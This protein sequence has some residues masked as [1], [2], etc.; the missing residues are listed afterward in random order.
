ML[1]LARET[2][3][4]VDLGIEPED[5]DKVKVAMPV[6]LS[7]VFDRRRTLEAKVSQVHGMV[8]PRTQ[9]V[10]VVVRLHDGNFIPGMQVRG[11]IALSR[12]ST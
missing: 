6:R 5:S 11:E 10:D 7:S 4:R 2:G 3:L 8:D 1:Q 12:A 9:L